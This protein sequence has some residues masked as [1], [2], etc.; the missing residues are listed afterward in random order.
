MAKKAIE[1]QR[2]KGQAGTMATNPERRRAR[3]PPCGGGDRV[4][5][6]LTSQP[7]LRIVMA[8]ERNKDRR[9]RGQVRGAHEYRPL[10][11]LLPDRSA[12]KA[13][14][15]AVERARKESGTDRA[16]T[17]AYIAGTALTPL[18]RPDRHS[19]PVKNPFNRTAPAPYKL[20]SGR[21]GARVRRLRH[22]QGFYVEK[23][24]PCLTWGRRTTGKLGTRRL[25]IAR[26]V[27]RQTPRTCGGVRRRMIR[28][29]RDSHHRYPPYR[30]PALSAEQHRRPPP[31]TMF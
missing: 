20:P 27:Q 7:I 21:R 18:S 16:A 4:A 22:R 3:L 17:S 15:R 2:G 14:P 25:V 30:R 28:E 5:R 19:T 1:R 13:G 9:A 31:I 23:I 26:C 24:C 8:L 29:Q 10:P 11:L 12:I 6:V